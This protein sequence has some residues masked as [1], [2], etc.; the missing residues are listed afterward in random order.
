MTLLCLKRSNSRPTLTDFASY[1]Y[2][3][4]NLKRV[5][6]TV[7]VI[8]LYSKIYM[9]LHETFWFARLLSLSIKHSYFDLITPSQNGETY[10]FTRQ[11]IVHFQ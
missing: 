2:Y 9:I 3:Q 5:V 11:K 1:P 7:S 4:K 10:K 8:V 6:S